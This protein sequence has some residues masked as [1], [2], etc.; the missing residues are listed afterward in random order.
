MN[1]WFIALF[2]ERRFY[3]VQAGLKL[4]PNGKIAI[5]GFAIVIISVAT[6]QK[7]LEAFVLFGGF[8]FLSQ[9]HLLYSKLTSNS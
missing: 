6:L 1:S 9:V 7:Q 5:G 4:V 3:V 8:V 2:F